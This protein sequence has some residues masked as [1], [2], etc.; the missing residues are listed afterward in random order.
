MAYG[1]T[2]ERLAQLGLEGTPGTAVPATQILRGPVAS[3]VDT[4][5]AVFPDE[6][7]GYASQE[8]REYIPSMQCEYQEP[9]AE[10]SFE[11]LPIRLSAAIDDIVSG[12][13]TGSSPA[14][15]SY[16][17][18]M[19]ATNAAAGIKSYTLEVGNNAEAYKMAYGFVPS[20][21]LKGAINQA[22]MFSALWH[23]RQK[24]STSFTGSLTPPTIEEILFNNGKLY[25]DA[26]TIGNTLQSGAWLGFNQ[27]VTSGWKRQ[28]TGD[29]NL[30][31]TQPLFKVPDVTGDITIEDSTLAATIR[32]AQAAK[33]KGFMRWLF[34]G[35]VIGTGGTYQK[36][37]LIIDQCVRWINTPATE[38]QDDDDVITFP[39][40]V[41]RSTTYVSWLVVNALSAIAS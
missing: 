1:I 3:I 2:K 18:A 14:G 15:Y 38:S 21:T 11:Q 8:D 27:K 22:L 41:V 4:Q 25:Y 28:F 26:S 16:T 7:V 29:G 12:S 33:T 30:Y 17:Y 9:D 5:E 13:A 19:P 20:F 34:E 10:A 24:I 23:G 39:Y 37:T 40:R 35:S 36:K 31:F 6:N 32:T